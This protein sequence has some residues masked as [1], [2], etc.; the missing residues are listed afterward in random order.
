MVSERFTP[1]KE[2]RSMS[3]ITSNKIYPEVEDTPQTNYAQHDICSPD[4]KELFSKSAEKVD[5]SKAGEES[6]Q[7][8]ILHN[9]SNE[10]VEVNEGDKKDDEND[11][12]LANIR[13]RNREHQEELELRES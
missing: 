5:F 12:E 13:R 4:Q 10:H 7:V 3:P 8:S 9:S 6:K 11:E 2:T 1:N